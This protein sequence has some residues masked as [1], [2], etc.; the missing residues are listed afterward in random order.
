MQ[1]PHTETT[2]TE[3]VGKLREFCD[4]KSYKVV[5]EREIEHGLQLKISNGSEVVPVNIYHGRRGLRIVVG[6]ERGPL[7]DELMGFDNSEGGER[8]KREKSG[9]GGAYRATK[10]HLKVP[11][12]EELASWIG[13]DEAGKGDYFGPLSV[14]GVYVDEKAVR[15]LLREGI[16]DSKRLSYSR[17]GRLSEVIKAEC[18]YSSLAIEP[19][20]YNRRYQKMGNLNS[21]LGWAHAKVI[22]NILSQTSCKYVLVD[23]FGDESYI[24]AALGKKTQ[25]LKIVQRPKAEENIAVA[26]ASVVARAEYAAWMRRASAQYGLDIPGGA[27]DAV[28]EAGRW[29]VERHGK[30]TLSKVAK[31]HFRTTKEIG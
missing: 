14:A 7:R 28:V 6:G 5:E 10:K 29:L 21:L 4:S 2:S 31:L 16:G 3:I 18:V 11:R 8:F 20:K 27:S 25:K 26:A 24:L 1:R 13:T 9:L 19:E 15:L 17:I 22:G 30:G 12:S 23:K